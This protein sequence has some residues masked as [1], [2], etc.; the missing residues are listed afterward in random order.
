MVSSNK[1]LI[2]NMSKKLM[3][4]FLAILVLCCFTNLAN[5][6]SNIKG[7]TR[8]INVYMFWSHGCPHCA[9]EKPYLEKLSK[10]YPINVYLFEVHEKNNMSLWKRFCDAYNTN[11]YGVPMTFIGDKY[12]IG[13]GREGDA[14]A[15]EI[16]ETIEKFSNKKNSYVDG[17]EKVGVTINRAPDYSYKK[18]PPQENIVV[19]GEENKTNEV[20]NAKTIINIPVFGKIDTSKISLPLF[21]IAIAGLDGFN[22]CAMWVLCFLLTLLVYSRSRKKMLIIGSI[23][24]ISSGVIYFLFMTAWLNFFLII[25]YVNLLRIIIGGFAIFMGVIDI[26]DFFLF[27]KGISLTIPDSLKPKL[28][29]KMR[30]VV[31]SAQE[32]ENSVSL[33]AILGTVALAVSANLIE[34][35][36]TAGFPAIYTRVLTLRKL[37]I[38][39]YYLYLVMYNIIYV[40]PLFVIV[41]VFALTVGA[42]KFSE[43]QGRV[44]KLIGGA[45]ML[46][47][48]I[49]LIYKPELLMFG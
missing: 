19:G 37:P 27:K 43:K 34:L 39:T 48:G 21:T 30:S 36:C 47:L 31:K 16:R 33:M 22:P 5:A 17:A 42:H 4:L 15:E 45:L 12:I 32:S 3:L 7:N 35:L 26:K 8:E 38:M 9:A 28:F 49:L 1:K 6:T 25:G 29:K 13:F 20:N 11:P 10:S 14:L 40:I 46:I 2:H 41:L 44:L 23:F 24:V 18:N